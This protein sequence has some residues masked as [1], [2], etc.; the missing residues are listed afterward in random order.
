MKS[1]ICRHVR[2][3]NAYVPGEQMAGRGVI[4]LNTNETPY[5]PS[6]RVAAAIRRF[7]AADLRLYPDPAWRALRAALADRHA[8]SPEQ[9]FVGN[10]SDEILRLITLAFV[11]DTGSLAMFTPS[12]SLYDTLAA[13]RNVPM[14]KTPLAPDFGWQLPPRTFQAS[15]FFLACPNNPTGVAYPAV[16][17]RRL[18]ERFRGILVID[19]AYADFAEADHLELA[20]T[21]PNV[22]VLRTLSKSYALAGARL[23]Y[24]IGPVP[25]I[26]ALMTLKDSYNVNRLTQAAA[27]AAVTDRAYQQKLVARIRE[28]RRM[29]ADALADLAFEVTPSDANFLWVRPTRIGARTLF[30]ALRE[31]RILVRYNP[32]DWHPDYLRITVGTGREVAALLKAIRAI[33]GGAR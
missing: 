13:A 2:K 33:Q 11:E 10:G 22:L 3:L 18:A 4:K 6:P 29:L 16:A 17:V 20:R 19:E 28:T 15:V 23:G 32:A 12:Y 21:R 9:V 5:P 27:L 1:R 31:R 14:R 26:A 8:V 30:D 25:L 7:R 24:A